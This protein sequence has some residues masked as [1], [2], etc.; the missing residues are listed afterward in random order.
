MVRD[1][2][3]TTDAS[4][5][6][7]LDDALAAALDGA[8]GGNADRPSTVRDWVAAA[9]DAV[10]GG[11]FDADALAVEHLCHAEDGEHVATVAP[12]TDAA[13]VHR[14]RCF[15]DGL[16]LAGLV[17][18]A[19]AVETPCPETGE[20]VTFAGT[21]DEM[22]TD[23]AIVSLGV[24]ADAT[25]AATDGGRSAG[26]K[27]S[28]GCGCGPDCCGSADATGS[29]DARAGGESFAYDVICPYVNAFA[30]RE[31]YER[32]SASTDA[33]T[34]AVSPAVA[35]LVARELAA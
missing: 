4:L 12:G 7:P 2:I 9:R 14:F 25:P 30:S 28:A 8:R 6:D 10:A 35:V 34:T 20:T 23:A 26:P 15:L 22:T 13:T 29:A 31:A 16:V 24:A 3:D 1:S 21:L 5:D 19:V 27:G 18:D 11:G 33:P 17:D 32:W